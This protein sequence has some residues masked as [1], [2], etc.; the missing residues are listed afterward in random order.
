[1]GIIIF[2]FTII[3]V[4]I[5]ILANIF[6]WTTVIYVIIGIFGLMII[7]SS[8]MS[9]AD[10]SFLGGFRTNYLSWHTV[11]NCAWAK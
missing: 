6:T 9:V 7:I 4:L 8:I 1:M 11:F 2:V 5:A 3:G 10:G